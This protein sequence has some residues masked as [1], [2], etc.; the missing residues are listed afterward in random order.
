MIENTVRF[1]NTIRDFDAANAEDPNQVSVEG[2]LVAKEVL[3]AQR[4]TDWLH[5][6]YPNASETLQLATRCQHIGRWLIP[7]ETYEAGRV[8]YIRWRN[9]LKDLHEQKASE[10]L[11]ANGYDKL[12]IER[13]GFLI[14]KKNLKKD[15][16]T[17]ALEDVICLVFLEYYLEDFS[18][19]H[20]EEKVID[21]LQKTWVKMS[22]N[23]QSLALTIPFPES[24]ATIIK[25]AL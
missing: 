19:K 4:M 11:V 21:I 5:K 17:Q 8:G 6:S 13:V 1:I 18:S 10:I 3:Y 23:G 2:R 20:D 7:R 9:A 14:Q 12:F 25:K 24:I 22:E 15:E 16:E